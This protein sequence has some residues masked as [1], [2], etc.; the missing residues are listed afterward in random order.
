MASLTTDEIAFIKANVTWFNAYDIYS[1]DPEGNPYLDAN[2]N[3]QYLW[4]S[5]HPAYN[6]GAYALDWGLTLY[7]TSTTYTYATSTYTVW[8]TSTTSAFGWTL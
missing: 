1:F 5:T 4:D 6:F 2:L 3:M 8:G 7:P